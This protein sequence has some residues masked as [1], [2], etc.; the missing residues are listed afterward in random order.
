MQRMARQHTWLSSDA[1]TNSNSSVVG[2]DLHSHSSK[3]VDAP[4]LPATGILLVD[5][6]R[7]RNGRRTRP[8]DP[9]L[10]VN[11]VTVGSVRLDSSLVRGFNGE[12]FHRSYKRKL[13]AAALLHADPK[14]F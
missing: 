14:Y 10:I 2:F 12:G 7:I 11:V 6:H 9:V 3:S 8:V 13:P 5:A 1:D 4:G